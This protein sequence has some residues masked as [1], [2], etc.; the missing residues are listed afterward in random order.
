MT[1]AC[2]DYDRTE[3]LSS[4]K[5]RPEGIDLNCITL[6]VQETFFRMLKYYEFDASEMSMAS[7]TLSLEK[8][9][10]PM[11]AIP[12]FPSRV[13]RHSGI[14]VNTNSGIKEP[15]D[16]IGKRVGTAEWQLTAGVWIRGILSDYYKVPLSSVS[17][18]TG[19]EERPGRKEKM[20]IANLPKD[21]KLIDIGPGKTLSSMLEAG[22]IDALYSPR[23]PSCYG[24]SELVKRLFENPRIEEEKYFRDTKIFPIMHTVVLKRDVYESNPWVAR[25]LYKAFE[26]SKRLAS[27]DFLDSDKEGA[28]KV[29][30]PFLPYHSAEVRGLMGRDYWPYGLDANREVIDTFLKYAYEQGLTRVR[31]KPEDLFAKET[32]E[33]FTI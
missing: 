14:Y 10:R 3:A 13:F 23:T 15:R 12:V 11:I 5:V 8:E 17:Y 21:V 31:R 9:E 16:L 6:P 29:M 24:R 4:G 33:A 28:L 20:P 1:I 18:Y 27:Y 22:E 32:N 25:S 26:E 7:Y 19:G 30:D 2:W